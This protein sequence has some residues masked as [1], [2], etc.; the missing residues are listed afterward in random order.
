MINMMPYVFGIYP[1]IQYKNPYTFWLNR[2]M[3]NQQFKR[4]LPDLKDYGPNPFVI[5]IDEATDK[6]DTFRTT[7]W[8]GNNLQ[9]TLMSIDV[10]DD[11]ELEIHKIGD[12]FIRIEEGQGLVKMGD[13]KDKLDFQ[14]MVYEGYAIM[15]PAGKW[16]NII[17]IGNKPLKLYALYAPPEHPKSTIHKTKSD[18]KLSDNDYVF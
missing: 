4:P 11:I 3:C 16:H 2:S 13:N 5:N 18:A 6:N 8:T 15:I 7:L 14:K 12:Q 10:G 1:Q 9:V 17:N